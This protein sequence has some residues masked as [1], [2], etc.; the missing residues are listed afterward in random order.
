MEPLELTKDDFAH[1]MQ[2][3]S[4]LQIEL[5]VIATLL[6]FLCGLL[7]GHIMLRWWKV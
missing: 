4:Q 5:I 2:F 3:M 7:A 6:V 1:I